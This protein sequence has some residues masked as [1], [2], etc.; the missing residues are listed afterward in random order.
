MYGG[1][2]PT[3][4]NDT[5]FDD[6]Y[7]LTIPSF[8]WTPVFT[9]G[10]SPRWGHNCHL[11]GNRQL[12]T[13]GGNITNSRKCD[14]ERKGL[15]F[16]DMTTITWGSVFLTNTTGFEVPQKLLGATGG[17]AQG[18]ATIKEPGTGWTDYRLK[19]VF[20]TPRK[21]GPSQ[22]KSINKGAIAGGGVAG[23]LGLVL[24]ISLL[25]WLKHR[26]NKARGPHELADDNIRLRSKELD[27]EEKKRYELQAVNENN[28]AELPGP[29]ASE[30]NAPRVLYEADGITATKAAELSGTNVVAGGRL[31]VP[32]VRTPGDDLP[33]PPLY[34]PGI[35][36]PPS[37]VNSPKPATVSSPTK[38]VETPPPVPAKDSPEISPP[39]SDIKT[40]P[41]GSP[42][43][44]D[45]GISPLES[46]GESYQD[47]SPPETPQQEHSRDPLVDAA[48]LLQEL[49]ESP[50]SRWDWRR[51]SF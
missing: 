5:G 48:E 15:A 22:K 6:V 12:V 28:P 39:L 47:I 3:K 13:V 20:D 31:G 43:E 35:S 10:A 19:K 33:T 30:L 27:D 46:S 32:I 26:R 42:W 14:W 7:V 9:D 8:T 25:L 4:Y 36:L 38:D 40:P 29:D 51:K 16:L 44:V 49:Q 41:P 37:D 45:Q 24:F 23:I 18:V 21:W 2:N 1:I 50:K 11:V 17:T 34:T